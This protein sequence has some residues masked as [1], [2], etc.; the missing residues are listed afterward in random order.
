MG[1]RQMSG[2]LYK[3]YYANKIIKWAVVEPRYKSRDLI[4]A[5]IPVNSGGID[6]RP[7]THSSWGIYR[8]SAQIN[9]D[10][11]H[12]SVKLKGLPCKIQC[13]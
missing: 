12:V 9:L 11:S 4:L 8:K 2:L 1:H 10:H 5:L 13:I 3:M 6:M 7:A